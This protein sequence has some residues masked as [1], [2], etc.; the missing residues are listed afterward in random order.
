MVIDIRQYIPVLQLPSDVHMR[1]CYAV[2]HCFILCV[3]KGRFEMFKIT[4]S[5]FLT[6]IHLLLFNLPPSLY[7]C[8][9]VP[10]HPFQLP[11]VDAFFDMVTEG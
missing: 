6:I 11:P 9:S 1:T 5:K 8:V 10:V 4:A 7:T 2:A 3:S